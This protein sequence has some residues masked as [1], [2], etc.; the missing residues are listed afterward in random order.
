MLLALN[1]T[2]VATVSG[3][4]ATTGASR[5]A[6]Y[7]ILDVLIQQGYVRRRPGNGDRYEL[8]MLVRRLSAGYRDE[9]WIR[10]AALPSIEALQKE[11]VWP[12]DI[13]TFQDN[14]MFLRET[15]RGR[16]PLT[17][18]RISVGVRLPMLRSATGRAHLAFC[19]ESERKSILDNLRAAGRPEDGP[20]NDSRLIGAILATTRKRGYGERKEDMF[21]KTSAIAVPVFLQGRLLACLNVTFIASV[22]TP[23]EAARRYLGLLQTAAREIEVRAGAVNPTA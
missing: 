22:L 18:D 12:T 20:V 6:V 9:D 8:T 14:A 19:P 1:E 5:P 3:L 2:P 23:E 16:S 7:R 10:E 15:T 13:A 21:E 11:V 17:I 4:A